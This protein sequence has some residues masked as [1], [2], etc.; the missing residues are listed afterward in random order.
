MPSMWLIRRLSSMTD[1]PTLIFQGVSDA[2]LEALLAISLLVGSEIK[3]E[4]VRRQWR[5]GDAITGRSSSHWASIAYARGAEQFLH[6]GVRGFLVDFDS[7]IQQGNMIESVQ[8]ST[9]LFTSQIAMLES[10][11]PRP[12]EFLSTVIAE[13]YEGYIGGSHEAQPFDSSNKAQYGFHM[14]TAVREIVELNI[15]TIDGVNP[16]SGHCSSKLKKYTKRSATSESR[17]MASILNHVANKLSP[18]IIVDLL[19]VFRFYLDP[20]KIIVVHDSP[21]TPGQRSGDEMPM[22]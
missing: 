16:F 21:S 11:D 3:L 8:R 17:N 15:E 18:F 14:P 13:F 5:V 2:D 4:T 6:Y 1:L 12:V 10:L 20:P 7:C 19:P 9:V 22:P